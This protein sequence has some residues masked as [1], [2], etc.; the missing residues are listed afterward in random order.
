MLV[1]APLTVVNRNAT[2]DGDKHGAWREI[3]LLFI[4]GCHVLQILILT[5]SWTWKFVHVAKK[6]VFFCEFC[7]SSLKLFALPLTSYIHVLT[8]DTLVLPT[9]IITCPIL[10]FSSPPAGPGSKLDRRPGPPPK[11][12]GPQPYV[13][14]AILIL[15]HTTTCI[16]P[17]HAWYKM[18]KLL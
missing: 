5:S 7:S 11:S 16:L 14:S 10:G 1:R 12:P 6:N 17:P 15:Q 4:I 13:H 18:P 3:N 2:S 9:P 8:G